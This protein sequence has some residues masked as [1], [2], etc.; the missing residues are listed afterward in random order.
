MV[1][2]F[3]GYLIQNPNVVPFQ[4]NKLINNNVHVLNNLNDLVQQHKSVQ[5]NMPKYQQAIQNN[6]FEN[7]STHFS[8]NTQSLNSL[9]GSKKKSGKTLNIIEEMLQPQKIKKDNKD[10]ESNF[11]NRLNIQE[12]AK[13]KIGIQMT[14]APYKCILKNNIINKPVDDIELTDLLVHK[15]IKSIDA[16]V[17]KFKTEFKKKKKEKHEV[18]EELLIEFHIDN[19]DKH[20]K[21]FEYKESFI[22]NLAFEQNTFD[23]S[24]EDYIEFYRQ[25]QKEAEED[26][27]LCDQILHNFIDEG[28]ISK[29][30]LPTNSNTTME[31]EPDLNSIVSHIEIDD[32]KQLN[33]NP[34]QTAQKQTSQ[35]QQIAKSSG[36]VKKIVLTKTPNAPSASSTP[37]TLNKPIISTATNQKI[38]VKKQIPTKKPKDNSQTTKIILSKKV[39]SAKIVRV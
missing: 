21:K 20:K 4:N 2:Q 14:N 28:I 37:S 19:Y 39:N 16:D 25:K 6:E 1:S 30:E 24:K 3:N 33:K 36:L 23:E 13:E 38:T 29:D 31:D 15:S 8:A 35:K 5:Q 26:K 12:K 34:K 18:N 27:K 32:E 7:K 9:S 11:K 22:R 10:V 17:K